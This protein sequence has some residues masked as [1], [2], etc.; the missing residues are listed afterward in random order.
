MANFKKWFEGNVVSLLS[1]GGIVTIA[2]MY[3]E[4]KGLLFSNVENRVNTE[5]FIE[6]RPTPGEERAKIFMDSINNVHAMQSRQH[7]DSVLDQILERQIHQDSINLR[8]ADQMYQIKE[9]LKLNSYE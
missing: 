8:N 6:A 5:E 4:A 1:L 2:V 7:R 9:Q 3:G